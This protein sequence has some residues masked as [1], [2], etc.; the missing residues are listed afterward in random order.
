MKS[1]GIVERIQ[2]HYDEVGIPRLDGAWRVTRVD[3][4]LG[5]GKQS[6]FD[7][8]I[9]PN[10]YMPKPRL[11]SVV[12]IDAEHG[13]VRVLGRELPLKTARNMAEST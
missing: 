5:R 4:P 10:P 8:Y 13:R 12:A 11:Y 1:L 7:V 3:V 2:R 9:A 6:T